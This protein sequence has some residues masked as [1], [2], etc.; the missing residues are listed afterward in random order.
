MKNKVLFILHIPP[1]VHGSSMVGGYIKDSLIINS[2]F[3]TQYINL[4]TSKSIYDIGKKSI[5]KIVSYLKIIIRSIRSLIIF[6]PDIVYLGITAKG[7]GFYKDFIIALI[8]RMFGSQLVLHFHN[9]GVSINQSR[10]IDNFLYKIVFKKAKV[11]LLS[12]HLYFDI[13][14]YIDENN[15]FYCANGIPDMTNN[16]WL[17]RKN[18]SEFNNN[19]PQI[20]FLS[21]LIESKGVY[22]LLEALKL[23]NE[24]RITFICNFV[25][26][27][28]D[29][30]VSNFNYKVHELKLDKKVFYLGKKYEEDKIII[31]KESDIFV[32]PSFSDCFPLVLLEASQFSLP[33]ISTHEGAIPEII[34]E[35]FN[36]FLVNKKDIL[37]L[38]DKLEVLIKDEKLRLKMGRNAY[39]KYLNNYTL[40]KFENNMIEILKC[41]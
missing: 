37:A 29:V 36:G 38:S 14:K 31:F 27:E 21:N 19:S 24:K 3:E 20:L 25:G 4:G 39:L 9:K 26:G 16:V 2:E 30:S 6:K 11:I 32:H 33:M 12:K 1:P 8:V 10:M 18:K 34:K 13:E 7:V 41:V 40:E 15:V 17:D 23:L 28:G 35:G 22:V 5:T